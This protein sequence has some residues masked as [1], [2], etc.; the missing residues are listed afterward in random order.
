MKRL[1]KQVAGLVSVGV[2]VTAVAIWPSALAFVIE[3]QLRGLR[4]K[5]VP[6]TW[7]GLKTDWNSVSFET[8]STVLQGPTVHTGNRNFPA[9]TLPLPLDVESTKITLIPSSLIGLSPKLAFKT[10]LY[11]GILSGEASPFQTTP[12]IKVTVDSLL[13]DQHPILGG[14]GIRGG[15][16]HAQT[17][18]LS[19]SPS[20]RLPQGTIHVQL[21]ELHPPQIPELK[22]FL[23]IESLGPIELKGSATL[24]GDDVIV[25]KISVESPLTAITGDI[26][27]NRATSDIPDLHGTF[28]IA[29][30]SVGTSKFGPW[31]SLATNGVIENG[32]DSFRVEVSTKPC[33]KSEGVQPRVRIGRRCLDY[34]FTP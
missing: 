29:L 4:S 7:T 15:V 27:I 34:K 1:V 30:S 32:S 6:L 16:L 20:S 3:D 9:L 12:A 25:E 23:G 10:A 11:G 2:L 24:A 33:S 18:A 22:S 5:G 17:H 26:T 14:T 28:R 21:S 8:V 19:L 31:L 13:I